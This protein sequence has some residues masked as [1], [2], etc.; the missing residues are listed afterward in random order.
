MG[1]PA[2][3]DSTGLYRAE[4]SRQ[5]LR[6]RSCPARL[7]FG[8]ELL[9]QAEALAA[10]TPEPSCA[11][12]SPWVGR[13]GRTGG[14]RGRQ[15]CRAGVRARAARLDDRRGDLDRADVAGDAERPCR[16]ALIGAGQN[17]SSPPSIAKLRTGVWVGA[18][19]DVGPPLSWRDPRRGR[20]FMSSGLA[21]P[22]DPTEVDVVTSR[23]TTPSSPACTHTDGGRILMLVIEQRSAELSGASWASS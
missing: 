2:L 6:L 4:F 3:A 15:R 1:R 9:V 8:R 18:L 13:R 19:V 23:M 7:P 16:A 14:D 10:G 22:H 5:L 20:T 12:A 11:S 17:A 21:K